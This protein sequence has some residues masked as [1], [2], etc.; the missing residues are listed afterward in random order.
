MFNKHWYLIKI[1]V[2][3]NVFNVTNMENMFNNAASFKIY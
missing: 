1:L 3:W 2:H